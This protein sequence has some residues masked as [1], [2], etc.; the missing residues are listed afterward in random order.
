MAALTKTDILS[1]LF[2]KYDLIFDSKNPDSKDNDVYMHKHYKII[3]R[4][5]IEKIQKGAGI[6]IKYE[7]PYIS[8][9]TCVIKGT[10]YFIS[11]PST[12]IETYGSASSLTSNNNYYPEM[13]EKRCMSRLVLKLAGLYELGVFGQDESDD[14]DKEST[15]TANYKGR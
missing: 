1:G 14:F 2:K 13:A 12:V 6:V 15:K 5:G 7:T 11:D 10:G 3:T 9:T 8:E 4:T